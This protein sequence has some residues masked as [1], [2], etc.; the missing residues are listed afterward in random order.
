MAIDTLVFR[1]EGSPSFSTDPGQNGVRYCDHCKAWHARLQLEVGTEF[2]A[3]CSTTHHSRACGAG[4][5]ER[6]PNPSI[7]PIHAFLTRECHDHQKFDLNFCREC[8]CFHSNQ[9]W[10]IC[11]ERNPINPSWSHERKLIWEMRWRATR[12]KASRKI[13]SERSLFNMAQLIKA[14]PYE[15][16]FSNAKFVHHCNV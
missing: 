14:I 13:K 2:C 5:G 15:Y 4:L 6:C 12:S 1:E 3:F 16:P 8:N 11:L 10:K 7:D 9:G